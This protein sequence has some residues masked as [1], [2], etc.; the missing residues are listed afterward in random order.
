MGSLLLQKALRYDF[1][2][3]ILELLVPHAVDEGVHCWRHHRVQN[4]HQQVHG[5]E[6]DG[7]G[8]QVGKHGS[9]DKQG[10]H[11]QVREAGGKGFVPSLLR[12]DPQHG[13]QD[14]HIGHHYEHKTAKTD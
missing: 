2:Q 7:G 14:L 1:P 8:L 10:D 12:G 9:A 5:W 11:G 13:P 3:G 4:R 6:G